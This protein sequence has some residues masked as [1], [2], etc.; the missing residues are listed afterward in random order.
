MNLT[1]D[2]VNRYRVSP[3]TRVHLADW[4]TKW[5][6]PP[7]LDAL[8]KAD[9]KAQAD[10][11]VAERVREVAE[12]QDFLW[13]DG[14]WALLLIFQG[15]DGSGKD[16]T[17]KHVTSGMNPAGLH[18]RSFKEPSQEELRHDYLWRYVK[19]VPAKG[20]IGVFN[21]SWYEE[22]AVVRVNPE[23][24]KARGTPED[25]TVEKF[26]QRRYEDVNFLE[27]HLLRNGTL[28]LKFF[29]HISLEEQRQRLLERLEDP[30]K[31][32]KFS[33][34][35]LETRERWAEYMSAYE[36]MITNT[37]TDHAPWYIVPADRKWAMRA[38]VAQTVSNAIRGL[39]LRYPPI[40]EAKRT[41]IRQ[42]IKALKTGPS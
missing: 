11:F 8:S 7:E 6:P 28:V 19:E 30:K 40:D 31:Q 2:A 37:S 36:A 41:A 21:R 39:G 23:L 15:M 3:G 32:W 12:Y 18:V 1:E 13:A 5:H 42:A 27:R 34:S 29:L 9:Q 17:I 24:L 4:D 10:A 26:W 25:T 35:D 33:P 38:L 20:I 16:S 14:R 22:L